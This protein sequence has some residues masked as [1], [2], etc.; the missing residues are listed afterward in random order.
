MSRLGI[1]SALLVLT[2][3]LSLVSNADARRWRHSY[4][5]GYSDRSGDDDGRRTR[6]AESA[7]DRRARTD[8]G[9]FGAVIDRLV[10]GCLQQAVELQSWRL[11]EIAQIVMPDDAQRG[12]L[13]VL[14]GAI[15]VAAE[16]L[17]A[18]CPQDVPM[19]PGE[20]LRAVEQA[21][22]VADAAFSTLEPAV[23]G[24]YAALD[25]EQKARLL[26]SRVQAQV[27]Q[28]AERSSGSA[29]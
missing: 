10:R 5:Q 21:I 4:G 19:A 2:L 17:S 13:E 3:S 11:E 6:A 29:Q 26:L 16:R 28:G 20:R 18:E 15:P 7:E 12:A 14:R 1:L 23:R 22:N 8:G 27:R 24:F 25:D 9:T